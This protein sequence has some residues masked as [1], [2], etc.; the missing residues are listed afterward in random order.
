MS[1]R[2]AQRLTAW[3]KTPCQPVERMAHPLPW[4]SSVTC[5]RKDRK[6]CW[7]ATRLPGSSLP[8]QASCPSDK[9]VRVR[10]GKRKQSTASSQ[11]ASQISH[12]MFSKALVDTFLRTPEGTEPSPTTRL[13]AFLFQRC[14]VERLFSCTRPWRQAQDQRSLE[15]GGLL[16]RQRLRRSQGK[17]HMSGKVESWSRCVTFG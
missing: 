17:Y 15:H 3:L 8:H 12:L 2:S 13:L 5:R 7:P 10:R 1:H 16:S 6:I 9:C 4:R 14:W 11:Q